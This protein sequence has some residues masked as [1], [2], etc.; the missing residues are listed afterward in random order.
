MNNVASRN[1]GR[2]IKL[3]KL[4][5]KHDARNFKLAAFLK[6]RAALP[7][8]DKWDFDVDVAKS[9]IPTPEFLNTTLGDCVI[10]ARAHAT[11]RFEHSRS[12]KILNIKDSQVLREYKREG[13][14]MVEG[15]Q[16]L[17]V[18][19]SAQVVASEGIVPRPGP[20]RSTHSHRLNV[21]L[22]R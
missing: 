4:P 19:G 22:S 9:A 2:F 6:P 10:A 21:R 20:T 7:V 13:G 1:L 18:L 12:A 5:P 17:I 16:G 15:E 8:P 14:S 3:G 11:L